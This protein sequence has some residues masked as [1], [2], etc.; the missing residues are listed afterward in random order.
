M[1]E[2]SAGWLSSVNAAEKTAEASSVI[3]PETATP[4]T[5]K[6]EAEMQGSE[7]RKH[8]R[9]RCEGIAQVSLPHAGLRISGQISDLSVAGCFIEAASVKFERGT[10]VEVYFETNRL[11][12]RVA[13]NVLVLRPG[14]G[15]GILFLNPN[16]RVT[17]QIAEL[18]QELAEDA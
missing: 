13:G 14:L 5:D 17:R 9:Y 1:G 10:Q 8:T 3:P 18:I 2:E 7:R 6:P 11:Q 12:F 16:A 15:V 4:E